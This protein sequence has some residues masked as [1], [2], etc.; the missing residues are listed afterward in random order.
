GLPALAYARPPQHL[1][2]GFWAELLAFSLAEPPPG[3]PRDLV[4]RIMPDPVVARKETVIQAAV[5]AAGFP[6]PA[7]RASGGPDSGLGRAFMGMDR[8]AAAP[9]LPSLSGTAALAAGVRLARLLPGVLASAMA[10][11]HALDPAPVR[12]QLGQDEAGPVSVSGLLDF[13][14]D[15]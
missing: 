2:G 12:D 13:I 10:Q 4:A 3:W 14:A 7:V 15:K 11:L 8:V 9:L 5:S 1:T 6:T